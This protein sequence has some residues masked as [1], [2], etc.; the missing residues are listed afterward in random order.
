MNQM[1]AIK[2][3]IAE[4][5]AQFNL[6]I[7]ATTRAL[8]AAVIAPLSTEIRTE[9]DIA[10]GEDVRQTLDIYSAGG[11]IPKPVLLFVPGGAFVGGDKR[12]DD[13]FYANLAGWFAGEGFVVVTM[14]YRLAPDHS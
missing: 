12:L 8:Y 4:L 9:Y 13:I 10:Y 7:L 11:D 1:T 5:G 14:N 2:A 6:D 3:K